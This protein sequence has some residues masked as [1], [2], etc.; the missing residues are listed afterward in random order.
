MTRATLYGFLFICTGSVLRCSFPNVPHF[1]RDCGWHFAR[2]HTAARPSKS[3][4]TAGETQRYECLIPFDVFCRSVN[5]TGTVHVYMSM[6]VP[7]L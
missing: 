4:H 2:W 7:V 1:C 6:V 3:G 5:K